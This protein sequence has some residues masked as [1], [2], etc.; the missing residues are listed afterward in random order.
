MNLR[1]SKIILRNIGEDILSK[2]LLNRPK[3]GFTVDYAKEYIEGN[4]IKVLSNLDKYIVII[5]HF[6]KSNQY[7]K[8]MRLYSLDKI[9]GPVYNKR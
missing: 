4:E 2:E 9:L 1:K 3:I 8:I 6:K 5:K 7:H